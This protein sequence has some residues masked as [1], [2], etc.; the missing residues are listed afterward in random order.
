MR[1]DGHAAFVAADEDENA[2]PLSKRGLGGF[3]FIP[4]PSLRGTE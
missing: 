4:V 1:I 3:E 2:F